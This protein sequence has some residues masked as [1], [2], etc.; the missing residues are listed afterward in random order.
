MR[1]KRSAKPKLGRLEKIE[2]VDYWQSDADFLAWLQEAENLSL[3][4]EALGL[5]LALVDDDGQSPEAEGLLCEDLGTETL[6]LV[7]PQVSSSDVAH[8]GQLVSRA[9]Q[10]DVQCVVWITAAL[11]PSQYHAMAWLNQLSAGQPTFAGVEVELWQIGK[12]AMA[13]NFNQV[14]LATGY[15]AS[16]DVTPDATPDATEADPDAPGEEDDDEPEAVTPPEPEPLTEQQQDNLDFWTDLCQQLDR[17]GSVIKPGAP[18]PE[19]AMGFAIARA[20]FRL[21]AILDRDHDSLHTELLLSGVDAH[22]HFYLLAHERALVED[23]IGY[24]LIWDDSGDLTC[25]IACS[26]SEV[27]M[28]NRDQWKDYQTWLCDRLEQLY[29]VFYH[30]IKHLDATAYQPLPDYGPDYDSDPVADRKSVV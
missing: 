22:P 9:A 20:D 1:P 30:R 19:P 24:P 17:R 26:L 25:A 6:V 28:A 12:N 16:H 7:M 18:T 4:A 10:G 23:E 3:L 13:A 21:Y 8:L 2:P 11:Q 27:D 14:D 5:D 15:E 29:E